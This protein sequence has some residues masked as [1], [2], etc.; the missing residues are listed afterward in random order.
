[1]LFVFHGFPF[2]G[3]IT[4]ACRRF[5]FAVYRSPALFSGGSEKRNPVLKILRTGIEISAVPPKFALIP[6]AL[7]VYYTIHCPL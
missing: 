1:D 2:R 3:C 6:G 7:T 5:E 4:S